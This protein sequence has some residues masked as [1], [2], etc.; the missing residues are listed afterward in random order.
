MKRIVRLR[1]DHLRLDRHAAGPT[2][3]LP[4][5]LADALTRSLA[6]HHHG[7]GPDWP[8]AARPALRQAAQLPLPGGEGD[9]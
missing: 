9:A 1:I 8:A 6:A 3:L 7:S 4:A 5:E 2:A